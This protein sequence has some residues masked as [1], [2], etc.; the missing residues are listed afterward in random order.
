MRPF[1][2][3]TLV[4]LN[5]ASP[6]QAA[7]EHQIRRDCTYDALAYCKSAIAKASRSEIIACML[8]NRNKLQRKCSRHFS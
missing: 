2:I 5:F 7:D 1:V 6:L 4:S 8:Q 3:A